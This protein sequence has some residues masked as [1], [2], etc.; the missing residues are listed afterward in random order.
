MNQDGG[1]D[2]ARLRTVVTVE[3][4]NMAPYDLAEVGFGTARPTGIMKV[5]VPV[6]NNKLVV[7]S[8]YTDRPYKRWGHIVDAAMLPL[9]LQP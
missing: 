7:M 2:E 3:G 4:P 9:G 5:T 6:G 1:Y 8:R